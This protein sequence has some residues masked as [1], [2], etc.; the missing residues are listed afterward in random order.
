V[1][2]AQ[3]D[4]GSVEVRVG[5]LSSAGKLTQANSLGVVD[6]FT[7]EGTI[8]SVSYNALFPSKQIATAIIENLSKATLTYGESSARNLNLHFGNGLVASVAANAT[9]LASTIAPGETY[10][11]YPEGHPELMSL[12]QVASVSTDTV[13]V[14]TGQ[15][16]PVAYDLT[17]YPV[18]NVI[19]S[20][21]V[22][23]GAASYTQYFTVDAIKVGFTD[24]KPRVWRIWKA[25][26][27]G[28][29]SIASSRTDFA[30][31]SME[32]SI[33]APDVKDV[34]TLGALHH[35][36]GE[37]AKYPLAAYYTAA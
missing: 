6:S 23:F 9:T 4:I 8:N 19:K 1:D 27:G 25:S 17:T 2:S 18:V 20:Q 36:A 37:V 35:V 24:G 14:V 10:M 26:I 28:T 31:P 34:A 11:I 12:V 7:F 22:G 30:R 16:L 5:P 3:L 21:A 29:A 13:T 32:L 15:S 33:L